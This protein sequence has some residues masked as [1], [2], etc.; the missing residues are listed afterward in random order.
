MHAA[1]AKSGQSDAQSLDGRVREWVEVPGDSTVRLGPTW[2][3]PGTACKALGPKRQRNALATLG[4]GEPVRDEIMGL[5]SPGARTRIAP[6][7]TA[8]TSNGY[9]TTTRESTHFW[10]RRRVRPEPRVGPRGR[11]G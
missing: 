1:R 9:R 5:G 7:G 6:G 3:G 2:V 8:M 4:L 11:R 10:Q